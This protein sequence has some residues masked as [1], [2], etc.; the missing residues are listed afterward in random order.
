MTEETTK[1]AGHVT[2]PV[3]Q[4]EDGSFTM[5]DYLS[6]AAEKPNEEIIKRLD[7]I[8]ELLEGRSWP[9]VPKYEGPYLP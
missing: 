2:R 9:G 4:D 1:Q 3:R 8:I 7:R 6:Q 5:F